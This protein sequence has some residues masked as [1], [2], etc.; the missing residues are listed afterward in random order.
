MDTK[1]ADVAALGA[2]FGSNATVMNDH[3]SYL[4]N[5]N[6]KEAAIKNLVFDESTKTYH[7]D[8]SY[9]GYGIVEVD[10]RTVTTMDI[11]LE[12][13]IYTRRLDNNTDLRGY[14]EDLELSELYKKREALFWDS[15]NNWTMD[16]GTIW[17]N[18][19]VPFLGAAVEL[20][21]SDTFNDKYSAAGDMIK[22]S[23]LG[24][25]EEFGEIAES[26]VLDAFTSTVDS[27]MEFV[28]DKEDIES[29]IQRLRDKKEIGWFSTGTG[30]YYGKEGME[31]M[32]VISYGRFDPKRAR[33]ISKWERDGFRKIGA[34]EYDA[35]AQSEKD[36]FLEALGGSDSTEYKMFFGGADISGMDI[37]E[38]DSKA[39]KISMIY[40]DKIL[41]GTDGYSVKDRFNYYIQE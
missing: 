29:S 11:D 13:T 31:K 14:I 9:K 8:I 18:S 4:N 24:D 25:I 36:Q 6:L 1:Y 37:E 20:T 30:F 38:L 3:T 26:G 22:E 5:V 2:L 7:Y 39:R 32:K 12:D 35:A 40:D 10:G 15:L 41:T 19:Q 34:P 21:T 27:A 23:P 17:L 28:S 33:A 16:M